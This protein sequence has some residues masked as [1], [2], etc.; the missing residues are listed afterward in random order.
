MRGKFLRA[1]LEFDV[2]L[3]SRQKEILK[4]KVIQIYHIA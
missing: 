2:V 1:A 3:N 4:Q